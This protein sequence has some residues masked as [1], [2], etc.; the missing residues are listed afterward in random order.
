MEGIDVRVR[1]NYNYCIFCCLM[2]IPTRGM[3]TKPSVTT[4]L[5][6]LHICSFQVQLFNHINKIILMRCNFP[7][8]RA[9]LVKKTPNIW[10]ANSKKTLKTAFHVY[11]IQYFCR[12]FKCEYCERRFITKQSL[13]RHIMNKHAAE[14][15]LP[16]PVHVCELCG[17]EFKSKKNLKEHRYYH[18]E[19]TDSRQQCEICHKV[20]L[21][22][23]SPF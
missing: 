3:S 8:N 15:G 21:G 19:N 10:G 1:V 13:S 22:T 16:V 23:L 18:A 9:L 7:S 17:K 14:S 12:P 20:T 2:W 5:C 4:K 6:C 11:L